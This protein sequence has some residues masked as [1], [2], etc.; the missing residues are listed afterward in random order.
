MPNPPATTA[1][2]FEAELAQNGERTDLEASHWRAVSERTLHGVEGE[3]TEGLGEA[4]K[5]ALSALALS[6]V[7]IEKDAM[8]EDASELRELYRLITNKADGR[9]AAGS[10]TPEM[11][12]A[13]K[14]VV[15]QRAAEGFPVTALQHALN[16]VAGNVKLQSAGI[17]RRGGGAKQ[18]NDLFARVMY[19]VLYRKCVTAAEQHTLDKDASRITRRLPSQL[20]NDRGNLTRQRPSDITVDRLFEH[21]ER[22]WARRKSLVLSDYIA[23]LRR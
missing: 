18:L 14:E 9:P 5:L 8:D 20:K 10:T 3:F 17:V 16:K 1:T 13:I 12:G 2:L 4:N 7:I 21:A 15:R 6:A 11:I 22:E 23:Y 19:C